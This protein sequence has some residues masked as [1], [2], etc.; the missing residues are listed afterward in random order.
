MFWSSAASLYKIARNF[1]KAK[2]CYE[3][4]SIGQCRTDNKWLGAK[5]L[6]SAASLAKDLKQWDEVLDTY[7]RAAELYNDCGRPQVAAEAYG[8]AAK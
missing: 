3:R 2:H 6:E 5:H 7:K 1:E 4:A 8:K